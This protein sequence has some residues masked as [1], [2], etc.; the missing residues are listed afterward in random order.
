MS[1]HDNGGTHYDNHW[2]AAEL[3]NNAAHA[4]RAAAQH[5]QQEHLTAH[6]LSGQAHESSQN[7]H[8]QTHAAAADHGLETFG[9]SDI[10]ALAHQYWQAR[11]C[12]QGSSDEDWFHAVRE[13]R[14]H[15]HDRM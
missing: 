15:A 2:R 8:R 6:E 11:G 3:H 14:Q 4:H 12:P 10:A 5:G 7:A 1:S 9:H 13:L